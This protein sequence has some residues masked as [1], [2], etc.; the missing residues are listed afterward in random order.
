MICLL[1]LIRDKAKREKSP[2]S[3]GASGVKFFVF[4]DF[5]QKLLEKIPLLISLKK[6]E[7][8]FHCWFHWTK[9]DLQF[10]PPTTA[11]FIEKFCTAD[12]IEKNSKKNSTADSLKKKICAI[13][14]HISRRKKKCQILSKFGRSVFSHSYK[15]F[16]I[17]VGETLK[18]LYKS[19][20]I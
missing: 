7:K 10:D 18:K 16:R 8:I 5:E 2:R 20:R 13:L 17:M 9:F 1:H 4:N 12:F 14:P 11:D 15:T 3:V 6:I 19:Y